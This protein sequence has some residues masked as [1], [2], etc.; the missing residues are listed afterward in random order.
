MSN[1]LAGR[2]AAFLVTNEGIKQV[3][4]TEPWRAADHF[5]G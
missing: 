4:P 2:A 5:S 3:V 1:E